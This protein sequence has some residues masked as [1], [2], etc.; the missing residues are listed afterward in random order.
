MAC[1]VPPVATRTGGVEELITDG[2]D[3]FVEPVGDVSGQA[4]RVAS[5]LT[6]DSLYE[7]MAAAARRT[8][9]TRFTASLIIP[10]YEQYYE[11]I[12]AS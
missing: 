10:Q 8:A 2:V 7:R 11:Q 12:C 1:G 3:G 5:L 6:D 9:E 4:A